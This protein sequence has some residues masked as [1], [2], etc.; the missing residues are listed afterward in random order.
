MGNLLMNEFN[1][2]SIV[3]L[4]QKNDI[5]VDNNYLLV[6]KHRSIGEDV[7]KL[8]INNVY[9][10]IDASSQYL[11]VF[12]KDAIY[13]TKVSGD[14]LDFKEREDV[15]FNKYD[16]SKISDFHVEQKM[17]KH[18][19]SW[20]VGNQVYAYEVGNFQGVYGFVSENF[21]HLQETQFYF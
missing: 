9:N 19:I 18:I 3:K 16:H 14:L 5:S 12:T 8:L 20:K 17:T 7:V 4:L 10:A 2:D 1:K 13:E 21:K 15:L 11:L 6:T